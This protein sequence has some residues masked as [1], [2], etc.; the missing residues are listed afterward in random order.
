MVV[1]LLDGRILPIMS[2]ILVEILS[3]NARNGGGRRGN[4]EKNAPFWPTG[5]GNGK[6]AGLTG[7]TQHGVNTGRTRATGLF[8]RDNPTETLPVNERALQNKK[9][10][11]KPYNINTLRMFTENVMRTNREHFSLHC[12]HCEKTVLCYVLCAGC[13]SLRLFARF[14]VSGLGGRAEEPKRERL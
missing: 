4:S 1:I 10:W 12:V 11:C 5:R 6:R 9:R 13:A 2:T 7:R 3:G 8:G 14:C